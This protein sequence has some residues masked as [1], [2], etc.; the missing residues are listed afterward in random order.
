M[1]GIVVSAYDIHVQLMLCALSGKVHISW[2]HFV[3]A[4]TM[5]YSHVEWNS[6]TVIACAIKS[7]L[8]SFK[9]L[10]LLE[11]SVSCV[12]IVFCEFLQIYYVNMKNN[13]HRLRC[14]RTISISPYTQHSVVKCY[15]NSVSKSPCIDSQAALCCA[16]AVYVL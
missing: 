5:H 8:C 9:S 11:S 2:G 6:S 1:Y 3:S 12:L 10:S 7:V 15:I 13:K 14:I 4:R 16:A